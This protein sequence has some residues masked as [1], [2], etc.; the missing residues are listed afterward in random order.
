MELHT[1]INVQIIFHDVENLPGYNFV[2]RIA[3]LKT[4]TETY[5]D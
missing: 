4:E 2:L 5:F 3:Q 1:E